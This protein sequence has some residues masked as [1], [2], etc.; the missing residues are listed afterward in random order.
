M[1]NFVN[2]EGSIS[3]TTIGNTN[4]AYYKTTKISKQNFVKMLGEEGSLQIVTM[5]GKE[6]VT[7]NKDTQTD[8]NGDYV[9]NYETEVNQIKI[10]A[11]K[12]VQTG[13]LVLRHEKALKGNTDY[14]KAQV[15]SFKTLNVKVSVEAKANVVTSNTQT[16]ETKANASNEQAA[17]QEVVV[18]NAQS[19][20]NIVLV[21]P[22]TKY[23]PSLTNPTLSPFVKN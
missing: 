16:E 17:K 5:D 19:V 21:E 4:Y 3:P 1:D 6:L 15:E 12:P 23:Q 22:T 2:E 13:K 10:I 18:S 8:E 11:S 9:L 20:K 7:F 14:S